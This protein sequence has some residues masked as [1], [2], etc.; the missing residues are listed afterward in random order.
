MA[1]LLG[2]GANWMSI[3]VRRVVDRRSVSIYVLEDAPGRY[4]PLIEADQKAW[5]LE[6]TNGSHRDTHD[7]VSNP[8]AYSIY[9]KRQPQYAI[10]IQQAIALHASQITY[11][12]ASRILEAQNLSIDRRAFYNSQRGSNRRQ[13]ETD[14]QSLFNFLSSKGYY[15]RS[16]YHY[17]M[18]LA[19]AEPINCQ[20]EQLFFISDTQIQWAQWFC[21][22]FMIEVDTT[23]N[24]NALRLPLTILTSISN[25]GDSFP[26]A[27]CFLPSESKV[28][29]DF[30]FKTLREL[31]WEE[32]P[33][34]KVIAG[35]QAKRL[36]ASLPDSMQSSHA[37][38]SIRKRLLDYGYSREKVNTLQ[39]LIWNYL[40]ADTSDTLTTAKATLPK[41]LKPSEVKYITEN[42]IVKEHFVCRSYTRHLAN[43]EVNSTQ[44]AES[45]NAV[46]KK[47]LN[48]QTP[49]LKTCRRLIK[50]VDNFQIKL[51]QAETMNP[52]ERWVGGFRDRGQDIA[53][54]SVSHLLEQQSQLLPEQS[55]RPIRQMVDN[56]EQLLAKAHALKARNRQIPAKLPSPLPPNLSLQLKKKG[57]TRKRALTGAEASERRQK[58]MTRA[59]KRAQVAQEAQSAKETHREPI[60][61]PRRQTRAQKAAA[62]LTE[63]LEVDGTDLEYSDL[64]TLQKS[65]GY[66]QFV[67]TALKKYGLDVVNKQPQAKGILKNWGKLHQDALPD[68]IKPEWFGYK[69]LRQ[70]NSLGKGIIPSREL[71]EHQADKQVYQRLQ[72][73][74]DVT[75]QGAAHPLNHLNAFAPVTARNGADTHENHTAKSG[76]VGEDEDNDEVDREEEEAIANSKEKEEQEEEQIKT[77]EVPQ[78]GIMKTKPKKEPQCGCASACSALLPSIPPTGNQL[79]EEEG[80]ELLEWSHDLYW[81]NFCKNHLR[82]LKR[83]KPVFR[84]RDD[85]SIVRTKKPR[86]F[87]RTS[88]APNSVTA[89]LGLYMYTP[90]R[91]SA[92]AFNAKRG[93][94]RFAGRADAWDIFQE[95]GTI[96]IDGVFDYILKPEILE[97]IEEKFD[98]YLYHLCDEQDGRKRQ[99]F[100]RGRQG[101]NGLLRGHGLRSLYYPIGVVYHFNRLTGV[102]PSTG[103]CPDTTDQEGNGRGG[104]LRE[105]RSNI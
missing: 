65:I 29:F 104:S 68:G 20:L 88:Q 50:E 43:L 80:L 34:P 39:S 60:T 16:R 101:S 40:Q 75:S 48:R 18:D 1:I 72:Q 77:K 13:D 7:I 24:T 51:L 28:C 6:I 95:D 103:F 66:E 31:V 89:K 54:E 47:T 2:I 82:C 83:L 11:A 41:A 93:F 67:A 84:Y 55:E 25:T 44:R 86:Y 94:N 36:I 62:L 22:S 74:Q 64:K 12:Q 26:V 45:M 42:W 53:M 63:Q 85:L 8:L 70:L 57:S 5:F 96:N 17:E 49:I 38:E 32:Y 87:R 76:G 78:A 52:Q 90:E 19:T 81:A 97:L 46:L 10:A 30:I 100:E 92:F 27:F 3:R 4:I 102:C 21:S 71:M 98:M 91:T 33:P 79:G 105:P 61:L 15:C 9:A 99:E 37:F 56:N 23:F 59:Q 69:I 35:D 73:I 14:L 58:A